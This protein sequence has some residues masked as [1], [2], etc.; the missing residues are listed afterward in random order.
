MIRI[1][2]DK[3]LLYILVLT[4]LVRGALFR[5]VFFVVIGYYLYNNRYFILHNRQYRWF[6]LVAVLYIVELLFALLLY[7]AISEWR[8]VGITI[9]LCGISLCVLFNDRLCKND[10]E[11]VFISYL[12]FFNCLFCLLG[13]PVENAIG[14]IIEYPSQNT[15]GALN[16]IA[17]PHMVR[18][19]KGSMH[20][21]RIIY[22]ITF[23]LYLG[24]NVGTT[25][26]FSSAIVVVWIV[27]MFVYNRVNIIKLRK[28]YRLCKLLPMFIVVM[29]VAVYM[30]NDIRN[31]YF[32]LLLS[33][34]VDRYNILIQAFYRIMF[35]NQHDLLWG[36]WD[37]NFYLL[38]GRYIVAHNFIL[39]VIIFSG[40]IG[41]SVLLLETY[42]YIKFMLM[43]MK[44]SDNMDAILLSLLF[45]YL[46]F[47]LHPVY[48]T[49]FLVK[50][51]LVLMN[52][53]A[54]F[55]GKLKQKTQRGV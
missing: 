10:I 39:E 31:L 19:F 44:D 15:L 49:S 5:A 52:L 43:R 7:G 22:F 46:F 2:V 34:D 55:V 24:T 29:I 26:M 41:F 14:N 36:H 33:T 9:V 17:I 40:L 16:M 13:E 45:G 51:F 3:S 6:V 32:E 37:N 12:V 11:N 23:I 28:S 54:S 20:L 48:T 35:S 30:S 27:F 38:S 8:P 4:C 1:N 25:V 42:I 53:R 21:L 47:L 50:L 18:T